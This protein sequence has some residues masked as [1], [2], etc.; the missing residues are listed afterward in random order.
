MFELGFQQKPLIPSIAEWAIARLQSEG[1]SQTHN[2][3][4]HPTAGSESCPKEC[5]SK[6]AA[7]GSYPCSSAN[8]SGRLVVNSEGVRFESFVGSRHQW[9]VEYENMN[10]VEK[11]S[12]TNPELPETTTTKAA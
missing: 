2:T 11:V 10:R 3:N 6:V 7:H 4:A 8:H 9:M 5:R 12:V 1:R